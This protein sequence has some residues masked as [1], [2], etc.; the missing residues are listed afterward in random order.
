MNNISA[1]ARVTFKRLTQQKAFWILPILIVFHITAWV[2]TYVRYGEN[3]RLLKGLISSSYTY[4]NT[5]A[6]LASIVIG[7]MLLTT[8]VKE[9]TLLSLM[10]KPLRASE[11]L[12]GKLLGAWIF[13]CTI[14]GMFLIVSELLLLLM[15]HRLDASLALSYLGLS[16]V[17]LLILCFA[18]FLTTWGDAVS[19]GIVILFV[20][21]ETVLFAQVILDTLDWPKA[22]ILP[23]QWFMRGLYYLLPSK[24]LNIK[25]ASIEFTV[26]FLTSYA[27]NFFYTMDM[28]AVY[29]VMAVLIFKARKKYTP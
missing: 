2:Y 17:A 29:F 6:F 1:V 7:V 24:S 3:E 9:K 5:I 22:V 23:L 14:L 25:P 20:K 26:D 8:E 28:I 10:T 21:E 16:L 12:A 11:F 18:I 27:W 13:L 15:S 4:G 19:A